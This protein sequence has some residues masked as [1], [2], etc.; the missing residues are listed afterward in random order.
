MEY[1]DVINDFGVRTGQVLSRDDVH[2]GGVLA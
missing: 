2:R 1:I